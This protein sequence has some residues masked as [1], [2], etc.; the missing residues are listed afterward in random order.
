MSPNGSCKHEK[1][2]EGE[3]ERIVRR[4]R[5]HEGKG[6]QREGDNQR[7]VREV[8]GRE[9]KGRSRKRVRGGRIERERGGRGA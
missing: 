6:R 8:R 7:V 1:E 3:R 4:I 2:I 9:R 5:R